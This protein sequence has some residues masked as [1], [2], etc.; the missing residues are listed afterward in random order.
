MIQKYEQNEAS[1][2]QRVAKAKLTS[3]VKKFIWP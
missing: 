2:Q 1:N 3:N